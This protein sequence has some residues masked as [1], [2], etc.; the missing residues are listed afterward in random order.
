MTQVTE[1]FS[2]EELTHSD[3]A[4]AKGIANIPGPDVAPNLMALAAG[5]EQ[6]RAL[7]E[8]PM[9]I[10]DGYRCLELNEALHGAAHSA[11][12]TCFAADFIC[13]GYGAPIDI[14][15]ALQASDIKFDQVIQEGSWV[16]ISFDPR[17]RQQTLTAHFA[18][19][20]VTYSLGV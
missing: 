13:P 15:K 17:M 10:N 12:E 18:D 1:H 6:V 11:H 14:V 7:L 5:L 20:K 2:Y 8:V 19:G 9:H 16:H 4:E 3:T